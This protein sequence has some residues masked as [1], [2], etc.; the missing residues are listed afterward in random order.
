MTVTSCFL[1]SPF[2]FP[3]SFF[4]CAELGTE[5][6][7]GCVLQ[8][9]VFISFPEQTGDFAML[10]ILISALTTGFSSAMIAFDFDVD[11]SKRK[12]DPS[13][14]GYI[15]DDHSLRGKCFVLM[16]LISSLHNLSR[17]LG[18]A[19]L[20]TSG[21]SSLVLY[22]VGGEV[23]AYLPCRILRQDF[24]YWLR[25]EGVLALVVSSF[26]RIFT[27]VIIDFSGRLH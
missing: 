9:Y 22:F 3:I 13:F 1:G 15:P 27:K 18:C 12:R 8:I 11:V 5:S 24:Y 17:S 16:T 10:S 25:L 19:L 2:S 7:P 14:Y 21:G 4:Q 6:I 20:A 23:G 26:K